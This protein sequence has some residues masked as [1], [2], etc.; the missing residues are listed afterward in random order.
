MA[1]W[2]YNTGRWQKLRL[3]V[4]GLSPVCVSCEATGFANIATVVDHVVPISDNG[5]VWDIDNLQALCVSCHS[6]KTSRG[7][8]AG[9]SRTTKPVGGCDVHGMPL[10]RRHRWRR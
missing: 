1:K 5:P 4:L 3:K 2:P 10:D 7:K 6:L 9:G 8:E